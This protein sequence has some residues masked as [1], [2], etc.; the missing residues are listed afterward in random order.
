MNT[1]VQV[2]MSASSVLSSTCGLTGSLSFFIV[3]MTRSLVL[4]LTN[5]TS[6]ARGGSGS[7]S[8]SLAASL[9]AGSLCWQTR[10]EMAISSRS[11][12][13]SSLRRLLN[14]L[15]TLPLVL[16]GSSSGIPKIRTESLWP[17]CS[18]SSTLVCSSV[19]SLWR[20]WM[21]SSLMLSSPLR[22]VKV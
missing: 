8:L 10:W 21:V 6:N 9:A 19:T 15:N 22:C 3:P 16:P 17:C 5:F 2:G 13:G 11:R 18:R 12:G 14:S 1:L 4:R 20:E 7:S